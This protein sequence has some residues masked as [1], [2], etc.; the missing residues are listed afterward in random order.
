MP[1]YSRT[2][3][4]GTQRPA[5]VPPAPTQAP[6]ATCEC[7]PWVEATFHNQQLVQVVRRHR[8]GSTCQGWTEP[9]DIGPWLGDKVVIRNMRDPNAV[10]PTP[11]AAYKATPR[12]VHQPDQR[13]HASRGRRKQ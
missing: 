8:Y 6:T 12:K 4:R 13:N 3:Q 7:Q 1:E 11:P 2:R 9:L 10:T 5:L